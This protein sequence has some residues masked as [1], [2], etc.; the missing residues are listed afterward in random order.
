M[1]ST[2]QLH[3]MKL[4]DPIQIHLLSR[5][6][7]LLLL[8]LLFIF[9]FPLEGIS[10]QDKQDN[11]NS[12]EP[13]TLRAELD[14]VTIIQNRLSIPF[15]E[16][17]RSVSI[18]EATQ[19]TNTPGQSIAQKLTY[20]SGVDLRQRGVAGI[21]ADLAIRGGTFE[22]TLVL[23]NGIKL[24]DPQ[25]GH[26]SLNL[27][28]NLNNADRVQVLKGPGARIYGQNAF[29]G[30]VNIISRP[31]EEPK[32]SLNTYGGQHETFGGNLSLSL[33]AGENYRQTLS[34]SHDR[35]DGYRYNTDY[36]RT[37]LFYQSRLEALGGTFS[38]LGGY[39]DRAFGANGFYAS[40]TY[41]DQ[42]ESIQTGL[43]SI[44]YKWRGEQL[45]I[46]PK[47]YWRRNEDTYRLVRSD[48]SIYE[49]NHLTD[50]LS[51]EIHSTYRSKYGKTGLG[52]EYRYEYI[53]SNNLGEHDRGNIGLFL[54][55]RF[56]LGEKVILTPGVFVN[57]YSDFG[58]SAFPGIDALYNITPKIKWTASVGR[59]YRVPTYT[60]LFYNGP[61]N[62]GNPNLEPE[63]ALTYETGL[64][65]VS[66]GLMAQANVYLRDSEQLID[67]VRDT[68]Q[69]KWQPRNFYD[70]NTSGLELLVEMIP[71]NSALLGDAFNFIRR[72]SVSYNYIDA[73]LNTDLGVNSRYALEHLRHQVQAGIQHAIYA[74]LEH[75]LNIKFA[76]RETLDPYT[77]VDSR[78]SWRAANWSL[79]VEATNLLD[80]DFTET[81]LVP[82]PG[83]WI[84]GGLSYDFAF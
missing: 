47:V 60:D 10:F 73:T 80:A 21:Q 40:P 13:D 9:F 23:L 4:Y 68:R 25:T 31:P 72:F 34:I 48:P 51:G 39:T 5:R 64:R 22:Q 30:A 53:D 55:H 44:G 17:S 6:A 58:W 74:K 19:L 12:P 61:T 15:S 67:W 71:A 18:L 57:H 50:V 84:K 82:M 43:V 42:W 79:Y 81:N 63:E 49:N 24:S 36:E 7:L 56:R 75:Q 3:P 83:R 59:T 52:L 54:E 2:R 35:S 37:N 16:A 76:D 77:V 29:T 41:E 78:L 20:A 32:I 14:E 70:V 26:H 46:E 65:Y 28:L 11:E 38:L 69:D 27:P 66:G 33:P 8:P 62:I 1:N 45:T